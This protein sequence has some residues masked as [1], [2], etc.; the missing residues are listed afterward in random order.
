MAPSFTHG[1][2]LQDVLALK[3][4]AILLPCSAV[5]FPPPEFSWIKG[6]SN[7]DIGGV[8]CACDELN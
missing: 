5:G 7:I 8:L 2:S 1:N 3:G 4:T 6:S